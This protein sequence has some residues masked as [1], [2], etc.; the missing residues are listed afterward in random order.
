[1]LTLGINKNFSDGDLFEL[2]INQ[3]TLNK[4]KQKP[5]PILNGMSE[6]ILRLSGFYQAAYGDWLVK[7]GASIEHGKADDANAKT[8]ALVFAE[9]KYR[10]N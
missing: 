4:D 3:L 5:A 7:L 9:I 1:M 6:E 2:V 8:D 10:L